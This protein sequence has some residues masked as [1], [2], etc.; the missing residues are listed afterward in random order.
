MLTFLIPVLVFV[1]LWALVV[2]SKKPLSNKTSQKQLKNLSLILLISG[3]FGFLFFIW[4]CIDEY[5]LGDKSLVLNVYK[6]LGEQTYKRLEFPNYSFT[7]GTSGTLY[8]KSHSIFEQIFLY[9]LKGETLI[10]VIIYLLISIILF[11]SIR[12]IPHQKIFTIKIGK[13]FFS[14]A[15]LLITLPFLSNMYQS[16]VVDKIIQEKTGNMFSINEANG[17]GNIIPG[18]ILFVIIYFINKGTELQQEQDLTI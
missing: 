15:I 3:I 14:I 13:A 8:Y 17:N 10:H 7:T 9:N 12:T 11:L 4:N 1:I 18:L 6:E 5:Y 16:L 2:N